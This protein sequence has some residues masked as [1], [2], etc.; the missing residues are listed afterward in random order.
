MTTLQKIK[1]VNTLEELENLGIGKV[2]YDI[3]HRGGG[4][5]FYSNDVSNF[6]GVSDYHLPNKF[7]AGCNYLGGGIRGSVYASNF[8]NEIQ[9][10]ERELLEELGQAC[11]RVYI[12]LENESGLNDEEDEYG[13]TNWDAKGTNLAR[14][15][16]TKS[17]Y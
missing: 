6:F 4:V 13:E 3:S 15:N 2:F 12:D 5:G 7:G 17:A 10:E 1:E 11:V 16:G 14:T 8:D 9:G